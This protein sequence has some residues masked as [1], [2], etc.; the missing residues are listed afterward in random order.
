MAKIISLRGDQ[1][2]QVFDLLPWYAIGQLDS[3]DLAQVEAHLGG[4]ADC[5]GELKFQR[6]LASE[7]LAVPVVAEDGWPAMRQRIE[8]DE[9]NTASEAS[10]AGQMS[11]GW[12][13][14]GPWL[15]WAAAAC[16]A[17]AASGVLL[18][19]SAKPAAYHALG[20]APANPAGNA[21]VAFRPDTTEQ[22]LRDILNHGHARLVDGPTAAGAYV[23]R[24]APAERTA[25]LALLR[26]RP[27]VLSA[28]PI[29]SDA[30]P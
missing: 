28:E 9:R 20:A 13:A 10:R 16:V 4:C 11:R 3:A 8:R 2:H 25:A 5:Q 26:R 29:D 1:H 7:L 23:L 24:V 21:I 12:R 15:G 17:L 6:R 22:A 18:L 27:E 30:R 19:P 14:N